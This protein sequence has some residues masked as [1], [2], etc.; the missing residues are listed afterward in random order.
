MK[1]TVTLVDDQVTDPVGDEPVTV[2]THVV[3][4][5]G[6]IV[7]GEQETETV[8]AVREELTVTVTAFDT[9]VAGVPELSVTW[10]SKY[11]VPKEPRAPV[12]TVGWSPLLQLKELPRLL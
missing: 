7:V 5:P 11:H 4:V 8:V 3:E 1:V 6:V 9:C 12:D 2:A 10:S